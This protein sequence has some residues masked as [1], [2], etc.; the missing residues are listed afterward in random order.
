MGFFLLLRL[1]PPRRLA[2]GEADH[3]ALLVT[4]FD[5]R[6]VSPRERALDELVEPVPVPLLEGRS[7]RLPVVGEDHDLVRP[8]RIA[9]R[10]LDVTELVVELAQGLERVSAFEARVVRHLV[11]ARERRVDGGPPAHEVG[12]HARHDQVAHEDAERPPHQRVDATSVAARLDVPAD[13]AKSRR[14]LE[15]DLPA[16]EDERTGYVVAVGE[17][18]AI[19]GVGLL[20]LFHPAD[21]ED[22][23]LSLAGQQVSAARATIDEQTDAGPTPPL[24]LRAVRRR[25]ARHHRRRLL[26]HP[27][28]GR[29]VLVRPQEDA[30][31]AGTRL[32]G[33]IGL[34]LDEAVRVTRPAVHVRGIAVAHRPA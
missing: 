11:I 1:R 34:P 33:E 3:R 15:D 32:R 24:D 25:R 6:D 8:W 20:L 16:E 19:A 28:E 26:L 23:R 7:L 27:A 13:R 4:A 10:A 30:R 9:A 21:R 29:D 2:E 12:E 17:E 14:P 5:P 22:D 31:L 18:S